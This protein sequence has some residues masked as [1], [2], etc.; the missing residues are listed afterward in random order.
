[1][2][3]AELSAILKR[4]E[5]ERRYNDYF[6]PPQVNKG[7]EIVK[8]VNDFALNSAQGFATVMSIINAFK[9]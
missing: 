2:S 4:E 3:D 1:M 5:A 6:S 9:G 8:S 7:W